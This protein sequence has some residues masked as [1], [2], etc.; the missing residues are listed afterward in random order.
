[1]TIYIV[2]VRNNY[3]GNEYAD[4]YWINRDGAEK[5]MTELEKPDPMDLPLEWRYWISEAETSD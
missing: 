1:M 5:R 3:S 2:R 4:S